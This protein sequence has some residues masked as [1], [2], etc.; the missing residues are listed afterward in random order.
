[1]KWVVVTY[2]IDPA[3]KKRR[4]FGISS[5]SPSHERTRPSSMI[6]PNGDAR[7]PA[8]IAVMTKSVLANGF[9]SQTPSREH[10]HSAQRS[11]ATAIARS[12]PL[13]TSA[14]SGGEFNPITRL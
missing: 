1:M 5:T 9:V 11:A 2:K 8:R 7:A 6:R 12:A 4:R 14:E 3:T 13:T 10:F